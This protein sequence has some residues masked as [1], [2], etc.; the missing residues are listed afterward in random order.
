[1][2]WDNL[3]PW[4]S[5]VRRGKGV[6]VKPADVDTGDD[7]GGDVQT[8]GGGGDLQKAQQRLHNARAS[9]KLALDE[10]TAAVESLIVGSYKW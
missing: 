10:Y 6:V 2:I 3:P 8:G 5:W 4:L 7:T 9:L 1:M